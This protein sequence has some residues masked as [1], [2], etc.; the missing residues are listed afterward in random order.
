MYWKRFMN[1]LFVVRR[2]SSASIF[3]NLAILTSTNRISP[4]SAWI[5]VV[6]SFKTASLNSKVIFVRKKRGNRTFSSWFFHYG[7]SRISWRSRTGNENIR[8]LSSNFKVIFVK[9]NTGI[10]N[11]GSWFLPLRSCDTFPWP[12]TGQKGMA[13]PEIVSVKTPHS[14]QILR[15]KICSQGWPPDLT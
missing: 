14:L 13:G 3:L 7:P 11:S 12:N 8:S 15:S 6:F 4:S 9:K 10:S 5:W 2:A 1:L